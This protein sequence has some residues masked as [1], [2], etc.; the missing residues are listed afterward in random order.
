MYFIFSPCP[1]G[2]VFLGSGRGTRRVWSFLAIAIPVV[3]IGAG[4]GLWSTE[5]R[6]ECVCVQ[7]RRQVLLGP[8]IEHVDGHPALGVRLVD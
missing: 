1:K 4:C 5:S 6:I 8:H 7:L 3:T 2:V